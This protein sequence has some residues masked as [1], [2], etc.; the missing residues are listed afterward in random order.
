MFAG[1]TSL[2]V[3]F[4]VHWPTKADLKE[5]KKS[6]VRTFIN[7]TLSKV[8]WPAKVDLILFRTDLSVMNL[9]REPGVANSCCIFLQPAS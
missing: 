5:K 9:S 1:R 8:Y 7:P 3:G 6:S 4:V 2:F